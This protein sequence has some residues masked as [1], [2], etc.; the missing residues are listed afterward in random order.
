MTQPPR[1]EDVVDYL[2]ARGWTATGQWRGATVWSRQEFDVLVP[3]NDHLLDSPVRLRELMQCVADAEGR[4][5][6]AVS[7]DMAMPSVDVVSYRAADS[8]GQVALPAGLRA[9]QAARNLVMA[10]AHEVLSPEATDALLGRSLLSLSEE[11]FGVDIALPI[12]PEP[13]GR[14]TA[15]RVWQTSTTVLAALNSADAQEINRVVQHQADSCRA[16]ADLGDFPF[17]LDFRWSQRLPRPDDAVGFPDGA[18]RRLRAAGRKPNVEDLDVAKAGIILDKRGYISVDDQLRTNVEGIWAMGDVNGRGGFTHTSYND[19]EIVGANLIDADPRRVSD[20]P[21]AYALYIDPPLGRVGMTEAEVRASGK[22]AL[23]ATRPMTRVGRAH[24]RSET[25]GFMKVLVDAETNLV[26]GASLLGIECDEVVHLFV[27][28]I[29][30]K[31]PYTAISRTMHIHPT[32]SELIP[33][34]LQGLKPLV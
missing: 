18:G 32:V 7:R 15:L 2:R 9:V 26:L 6:R 1:I 22:K 27:D 19:F 30:A 12:E 13:L 24:E 23:I 25:Q 11:V 10:G 21:T 34:L 3:P 29:A 28:N 17:R 14:T 20:R 4:P 8:G 5:P 16:L 31:L 33:T